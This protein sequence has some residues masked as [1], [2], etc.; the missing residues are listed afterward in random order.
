MH[1]GLGR[2]KLYCAVPEKT[3]ELASQVAARSI[4]LCCFEQSPNL[5]TK[6]AGGRT[7]GA[8]RGGPGVAETPWEDV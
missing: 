5:A 6:R 1:N 4:L 2:S 7:G 8:S 3:S